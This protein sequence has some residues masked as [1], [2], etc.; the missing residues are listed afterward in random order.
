MSAARY[1]IRD[2][3]TLALRQKPL[4]AARERRTTALD[5]KRRLVLRSGS[6]SPLADDTEVVVER[7]RLV[8]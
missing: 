2:A 4:A 3:R 6:A 1:V 8:E 7:F 5:G